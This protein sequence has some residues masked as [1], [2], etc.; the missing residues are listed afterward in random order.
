[1]DEP[2]Y[3]AKY[4]KYYVKNYRE[5]TLNVLRKD[6]FI[7]ANNIGTPIKVLMRYNQRQKTELPSFW[8]CSQSVIDRYNI[9]ENW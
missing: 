4:G 8:E 7:D 6:Y 3:Y 9:D 1:M 2:F 5:K